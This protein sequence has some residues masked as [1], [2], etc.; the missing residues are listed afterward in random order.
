MVVAVSF[1]VI[2][3]TSRLMLFDLCCEARAWL[4]AGP[5]SGEPSPPMSPAVRTALTLGFWGCCTAFAVAGYEL[6]FIFAV[7]QTPF[8]PHCLHPISS[9]AEPTTLPCRLISPWPIRR[10]QVSSALL[11]PT[12]VRLDVLRLDNALRPGAAAAE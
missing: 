8:T 11:P 3:F 9:F 2:H 1:P 10:L 12:G 4:G 7:N 5:G 6:G